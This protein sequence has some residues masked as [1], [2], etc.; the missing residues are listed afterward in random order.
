M[1]EHWTFVG[2][3]VELPLLSWC[4]ETE[5]PQPLDPLSHKGEV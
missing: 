3:K 4:G 5:L 1:E 2:N